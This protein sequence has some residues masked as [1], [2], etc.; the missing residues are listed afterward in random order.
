MFLSRWRVYRARI[1][2]TTKNNWTFNPEISFM[3]PN[4]T[5]RV[6]PEANTESLSRSLSPVTYNSTMRPQLIGD[7]DLSPYVPAPVKDFI[8][9]RF[10]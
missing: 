9:V 4:N 3:Y 6:Q 10:P 5:I 8:P 1:S 7:F 2:L